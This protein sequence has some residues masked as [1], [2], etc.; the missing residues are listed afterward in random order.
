[1]AVSMREL[2]E[3]GVHFGHQTRR[4]NPKMRRYIFSER[5]GIYIIDLTQTADLLDEA[6]Q[7]VRNVA[8]RNGTV[9]FVGT[10]KQ[11]Q[12]AVKSEATR[13]GMP[14]VNHRWL[15]GLLTNWRT[16]SDRIERLHDMR[17]LRDEGQLELLPAKERIAMTGELEKLEQNL[18][19]VADMRRQPDAVFIIDLRK[20]ALAVREARRLGLPVLA[21]VDTNC[22]P[23]DADY[24]IPGN[25]DAIRSCSLIARAVADA[26]AEGRQKVSARELAQAAEHAAAA[27]A[28]QEAA[29]A[30]A[31]TA[32]EPET[33]TE[34]PASEPEPAAE[35]KAPASE[36]EP[37]AESDPPA[38]EPEP[39][40]ETATAE[41]EP[42]AEAQSE[43]PAAAAAAGQDDAPRTE[44]EVEG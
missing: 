32:A 11:A 4:W 29:P 36:P 42:E 38:A 3:A 21:V 35:S 34:A 24:V 40:P 37:A 27:A 12:D 18:G 2:L 43:P 1:M 25:D 20:E 41:P 10:K 6:Q 44:T 7:F 19:G 30:P 28:R 13:V 23:D 8:E 15:G 22:D 31:D 16:M 5:G 17:R 9:L 39:E 33:E 26:I 14:Y